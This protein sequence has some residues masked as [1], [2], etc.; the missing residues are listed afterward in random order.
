MKINHTFMSN[1]KK[2]AFGASVIMLAM[3]FSSC[4]DKEQDVRPD[5]VK[6]NMS[7]VWSDEFDGTSAEPN[8]DNWDYNTGGH[9]WGNGERQNY[10]KDRSNSFV[11]NGTLK[12]VA[13]KNDSGKW[14]S[15]RLMSSFKQ[16][17]TYGYIEFRAKLPVEKGSWPALWMMPQFSAYGN[18]PRSGEI[19]VMEYATN[20][21]GKKTYG[22]VHCK[23][24]SGGN[25]VNSDYIEI[26]NVTKWHTYAVL[27]QEDS[28]QWYYDG[29]FLTEYKNPHTEN[30]PWAAWPFDKPF[31]I[32]MNVAMGGT[33]GGDIPGNL[34]KCQM[35]VDYVR[36]YQ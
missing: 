1:T 10:T 12:I 8:P 20:T 21:W 15:A 36:V 33:L 19:D 9:G 17:F 28:I 23:A 2:F 29:K 3:I 6:E 26:S 16:S 24:G 13:H 11:S 7:L 14:T 32:I 30:E 18:W 4:E 5:Y 22:T 35:E 31:Y 25:A 27:W 34:E